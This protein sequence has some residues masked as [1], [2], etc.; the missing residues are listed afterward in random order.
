MASLVLCFPI[1]LAFLWKSRFFPVL[2]RT[3]W[4]AVVALVLLS[5]QLSE[6]KPSPSER[7]QK[8]VDGRESVA[9]TQA[10]ESPPKGGNSRESIEFKLAVLDNGGAV[11]KSAPELAEYRRL[12]DE[13]ANRFEITPDR[14]AEIVHAL[15]KTLHEHHEIKATRLEMLLAAE[16]ATAGGNAQAVGKGDTGLSSA[17]AALATVMIDGKSR[18]AD[19][20]AA[21][22][23]SLDVGM[24]LKNTTL[25]A[26][27]QSLQFIESEWDKGDSI[28]QAA[29]ARMEGEGKT[30]AENR[31]LQVSVLE[32]GGPMGGVFVEA[33]S[34]EGLRAARFWVLG[35]DLVPMSSAAA[36]W[37]TDKT[38]NVSKTRFAHVLDGEQP[39]KIGAIAVSNFMELV[40][41]LYEGT[42]PET[43]AKRTLVL[44]ESIGGANPCDFRDVLKD[45]LI[46]EGVL[47][48]RKH[49]QFALMR[50]AAFEVGYTNP[51]Q[52]YKEIGG[53]GFHSGNPLYKGALVYEGMKQFATTGGAVRQIPVFRVVNAQP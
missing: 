12:L 22:P 42:V 9:T 40:A 51:M 1:G 52:L 11:S 41:G 8:D 20:A 19:T 2:Q 34:S 47:T 14:V 38:K 3:G 53:G 16:K 28:G 5:V 37:A 45:H 13:L 49:F 15:V 6:R 44:R 33:K 50:D 32:R 46:Y 26:D 48:A 23:N 21:S 17:F 4:T 18:P 10:N 43:V 25:Y 30:W 35:S 27:K 39:R 31:D 29:S 24:V 36:K 7:V